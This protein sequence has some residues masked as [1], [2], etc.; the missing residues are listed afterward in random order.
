MTKPARFTSADLARAVKTVQKLGLPIAS[1]EVSAESGNIR[2]EVA[3]P[4]GIPA[5]RNPL[6]RLHG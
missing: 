2:V 3:A 1:I 4:G 6:D 5:Y